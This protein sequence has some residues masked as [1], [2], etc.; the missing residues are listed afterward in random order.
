MSKKPVKVQPNTGK[1][2][3]KDHEGDFSKQ[4]DTSLTADYILKLK[5]GNG[6]FM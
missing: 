1:A 3:K 5:S 2:S 4:I 6:D